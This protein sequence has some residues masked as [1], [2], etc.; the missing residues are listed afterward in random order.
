MNKRTLLG[1]AFVAVLALGAMPARGAELT[2][3]KSTERGV[4][5]AVTPVT[6]SLDVKTWEF[7]VV[8][9]S[10]SQELSDDLQRTAVLV[11]AD[12]REQQPAWDG[13]PPGGHHREGVLRFVAVSPAS[14]AVELRIQRPNEGA[15]RTFRWQLR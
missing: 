2:T 10:H 13:A 12:G 14:E 1:A 9:D 6:L 15:A 3:Q 7:K 11:A 4:T 8:L 5:V